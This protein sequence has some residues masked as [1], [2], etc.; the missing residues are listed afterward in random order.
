M[1]K[2]IKFSGN[3]ILL[4]I[5]LGMLV[6]PTGFMGIM[7]FENS[8]VVLSAQDVRKYDDNGTI[9]TLYDP[10]NKVP[11]DIKE[12]I[13]RMEDEYYYQRNDGF[14]EDIERSKEVEEPSLSE[15]QTSVLEEDY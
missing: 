5:L 2:I 14:V 15:E 4:F 1:I 9:R 11:D 6:L 12:V 7:R 13:L 3:I 10:E 8:S